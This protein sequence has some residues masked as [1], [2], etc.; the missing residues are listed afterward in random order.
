M[1]PETRHIDAERALESL[2]EEERREVEESLNDVRKA[3]LEVRPSTEIQQMIAD[4]R[5]KITQ[6]LG[7]VPLH[8]GEKLSGYWQL[9]EMIS[10]RHLHIARSG[11]TADLLRSIVRANIDSIIRPHFPWLEEGELD[12][13]EK[14]LNDRLNGKRPKRSRIRQKKACNK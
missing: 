6:T 10:I 14:S 9:A 13:L 5:M 12:A 4:S 8:A 1:T 11:L 7:S 3:C 2:S